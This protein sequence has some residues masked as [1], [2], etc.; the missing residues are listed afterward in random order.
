MAQ[1]HPMDRARYAENGVLHHSIVSKLD[2]SLGRDFFSVDC[3]EAL[4]GVA[5]TWVSTVL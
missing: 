4:A 3:Y 5:R 2:V 1:D